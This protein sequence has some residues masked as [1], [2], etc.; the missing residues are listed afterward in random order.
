[1]RQWLSIIISEIEIQF[2]KALKNIISSKQFGVNPSVINTFNKAND[3][4]ISKSKG[5]L[6]F[7]VYTTKVIKSYN[8]FIHKYLQYNY[9]N[10]QEKYFQLEKENEILKGKYESL[11]Y[12]N[13]D[14]KNMFD[15]LLAETKNNNMNNFKLT[16]K[17][18]RTN[19]SNT[20][21]GSVVKPD[22]SELS[23]IIKDQNLGL[24]SEISKLRST[25]EVLGEG[26]LTRAKTL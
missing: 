25:V 3:S 7:E 2:E 9:N 24:I 10:E 15:K 16:E 21:N 13:N 4:Y 18:M 8:N 17:L 26:N 20:R 12:Q 11:C 14:Y 23:K 6:R 1:M 22:S 19:D 5:P